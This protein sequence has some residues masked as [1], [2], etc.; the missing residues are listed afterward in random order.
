MRSWRLRRQRPRP[1]RYRR[2]GV[3]AGFGAGG[4]PC[5]KDIGRAM[6]E[7]QAGA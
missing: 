6:R 4:E 7:G 3:Q 2:H 5:M 1:T